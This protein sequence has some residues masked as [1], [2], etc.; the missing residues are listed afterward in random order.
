MLAESSSRPG[1]CKA[2]RFRVLACQSH[3]RSGGQDGR[4][5][6]WWL[7]SEVGPLKLLSFVAD[8]YFQSCFTRSCCGVALTLFEG[9]IGS[10]KV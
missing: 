1:V 9:R 5:F 6:L 10:R 8:N 3:Q 7:A 2:E 4:P